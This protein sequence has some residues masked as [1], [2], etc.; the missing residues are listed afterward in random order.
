MMEKI[1]IASRESVL[2]MWQAEYIQGCL[3]K[4]YPQLTVEILGISTKGDRILDKTLSKIG[5]KGLFI[6]ELETAL[7]EGKAD[8]AVHSIKDVPMVL[9]EGFAL[10]A[11]PERANPCDAFVS[12]HY[13][14]L[15]TLP[16]GAIVGTASLRREAQIRAAFPHLTI[17]TLRGNVQTRLRK[18]DEGQYDAIILAAAGLERLNLHERIRGVLSVDE[19]LPAAGQGAL[20]IEIAEHR[21]DMRQLL[22]VLHDCDSA[23]C[24]L[25]ERALARELGGSCQ[26]PLAAYAV[27][28]GDNLYLRGLV[29]YPDGS[30][31]LTAQARAPRQYAE[32]LGKA[33]AK[34]LAED[35]AMDLIAEVL[36][37]E[38]NEA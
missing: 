31:V 30:E 25:A 20:G 18:L 3:K 27:L 11:I 26:V 8:L 2:A 37:Q 10:T 4:H 14:A 35:G 38:G 29:A 1:T 19:S 36:A 12:N 33:V 17:H 6:K 21:E 23:D 9:P 13:S 5:G 28:E 24:V 32:S 15:H 16:E 34:L 7:Q 22:A